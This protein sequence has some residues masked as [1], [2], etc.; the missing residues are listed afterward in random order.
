M[1]VLFNQR[2]GTR[3][4]DIVGMNTAHEKA[5]Q[6]ELTLARE[7]MKRDDLDGAIV[8][9]ERAHVLGQA[10]ARWH[11]LVHWLMLKVAIRRHQGVAALGQAVRIVLG[12]VGSAVGRVP[13]GN[14]GGS[15]VSMFAR[16]PIAPGLL[17]IMEST[18]LERR[19]HGYTA[20]RTKSWN[21]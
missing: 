1:P 18:N 12:A 3:V 13:T 2:G 15:E 9:L 16:M 14:T 17:R 10:H 4:A 19:A 7:L 20:E 11:V 6:H 5:L 21:T 8:R